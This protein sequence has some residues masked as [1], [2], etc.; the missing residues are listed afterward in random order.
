MENPI[1]HDHN[2][3]VEL[4]CKISNMISWFEEKTIEFLYVK[5]TKQQPA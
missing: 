2:K 1:Q 3:H 5:A 4:D